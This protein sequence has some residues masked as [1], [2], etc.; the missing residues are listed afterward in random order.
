[1]D[2]S[3]LETIHLELVSRWIRQK[4]FRRYLIDN[5]YPIAIDGTQKLC[6]DQLWAQ[7][8]L[9][10]TFN[11]G[12]ENEKTQYY[13][14][15]VQ[16]S[17]AFC[18]GPSIPVLSEFLTYAG[19]G[20]DQSKQD[21]ELKAFH[22]LS[23]R[24]KKAFP[25]L[26]IMILLDGLY[27]NGPVFERCHQNRWQ[28]MIVLKDGALSRVLREFEA[29]SALEPHQRH[30]RTWGGRN[31]RFR[32]VNDIEYTYGPNDKKRIMLHVVECCEQWWEIEKGGSKEI[33]KK[34]RHLWISSVPLTQGNLHER[35]NL[36]ARARWNIETSFLVEKR[37][38]YQ[39]EHC[40]SYN[41]NAMKGY[42]CLMQMGHMFN[43][44]ARYFGELANI[45]K[46]TGI[47]GLIRFVRD[48]I[49][50][51]WL[52]AEWI[53]EKLAAPIQLRLT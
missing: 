52:D 21:C 5:H 28:Y 46:D 20:T 22:R 19:N 51:P 1:L 25:C 37:H 41:W 16:A 35:C 43:E 27:A 30:Q 12:E 14:Y 3:A 45:I 34:K 49:S 15:V 32:W 7:E 36:G 4:K 50:G 31:Q 40:F 18:G 33:E 13:V 10:R 26:R 29:L 47:R 23:Q 9:E 8:C 6:R 24:L 2:V 11:K 38:G 48:T 53:K 44:M 39:Y 17:L 42:H